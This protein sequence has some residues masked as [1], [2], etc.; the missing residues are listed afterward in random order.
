MTNKLH[1]IQLVCFPFTKH[2]TK[3]N[4]TRHTPPH[5]PK[6]TNINTTTTTKELVKEWEWNLGIGVA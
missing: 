1:P 6:Q 3:Q 4:K 5:P 2:N